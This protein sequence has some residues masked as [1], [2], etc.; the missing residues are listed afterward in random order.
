[1]LRK[2]QDRRKLEGS[3][4]TEEQSWVSQSLISKENQRIDG[5]NHMKTWKQQERTCADMQRPRR[6][7]GG[8]SH[9]FR[10]GK[11]REVRPRK[12]PENVRAPSA[13]GMGGPVGSEI[14]PVRTG[15]RGRRGHGGVHGKEDV[16]GTTG[17][18][19]GDGMKW[20]E[21]GLY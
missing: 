14:R 4:E 10:Q 19:S 13:G 21:K 16:R 15:A 8:G 20:D 6:R 1:M 11:T 7:R 12:G 3:N 17:S 18:G 2:N 9:G 5:K